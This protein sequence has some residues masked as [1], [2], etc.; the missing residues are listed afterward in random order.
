MPAL[1]ENS[2][3]YIARPPLYRVTR[4]KT[5]QYIHSEKEMDEYLFNLGISDVRIRLTGHADFMDKAEVSQMIKAIRDVES[6]IVSIERKGVPFR[7]FLSAQNESGKLPRF[8]VKLGDESRFVFSEEEFVEL[9]KQDEEIQRQKH[10]ET[11]SSIPEEEQTEEMKLFRIKAFPFMELY[12]EDSLEDLKLR[13]AVYNFSLAQYVSAEGKLFDIVDENG[14]EEAVYTLKEGIELLRVNGRKGIEIQRYKGL[15]EM[16]ADQLW[17]TTMDPTCRTLLRVTLPDAIAA[18]HMFTMLMGE[19]VP[20][21]RAFI[22]KY[23][24]SVKNLDI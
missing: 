2:F 12:E 19:D 9:K 24:L 22:E 11:L 5:S 20:P 21:R 3:I 8:Q 4:K 16:N 18:D 6:L 1:I 10:L 7:E 23:A 17:E 15:G 13:L 14:R